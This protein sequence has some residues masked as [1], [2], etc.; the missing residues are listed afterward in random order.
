MAINPEFCLG[1]EWLSDCTSQFC[2]FVH[3]VEFTAEPYSFPEWFK[4]TF[5][6]VIWSDRCLRDD[7]DVERRANNTLLKGLVNDIEIFRCRGLIDET[8]HYQSYLA[9]INAIRHKHPE[10][11]LGAGR[12][13]HMDGFTC[14]NGNI[15]ARGYANGD[16]LAIVATTL[17]DGKTTG[18]ISVPGYRFAESSSIGNVKVSS[19][20]SSITLDKNAI[21]VLVFER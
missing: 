19:N 14:S 1:T 15:I 6:E 11:L 8:P 16:K 10:L 13:V 18:K 2:D 7:T 5:P 17:E 20:G 9:Q 21:T 4:Y 12:F 3:I